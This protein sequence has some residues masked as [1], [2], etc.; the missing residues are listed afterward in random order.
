MRKLTAE[1]F[2]KKFPDSEIME[3]CCMD[4]ACSTCGARDGFRIQATITALVFDDGTDRDESDCEYDE[5]SRCD[6]D[7]GESGQLHRFTIE[8]L[9]DLLAEMKEKA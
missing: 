3:N 2:V 5:D 6:C 7:C 1:Q 9:D 4:K 8:G